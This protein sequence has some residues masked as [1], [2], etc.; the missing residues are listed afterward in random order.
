[1][2]VYI[3]DSA[4]GFGGKS[5]ANAEDQPVPG[6]DSNQNSY[7]C[8]LY[9]LLVCCQGNAFVCIPYAISVE[10]LTRQ[11]LLYR[12]YLQVTAVTGM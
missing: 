5:L 9:S 12:S 2:Y 11:K 1:M 10:T 4:F 7:Y 6:L 3:Q 8:E